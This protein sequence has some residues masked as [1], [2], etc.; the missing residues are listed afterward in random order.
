MRK[1][2]RKKEKRE[3]LLIEKEIQ[4][5][6]LDAVEKQRLKEITMKGKRPPS[7]R[8]AVNQNSV[9]KRDAE[10]IAQEIIDNEKKEQVAGGLDSDIDSDE[11]DEEM[12]DRIKGQPGVVGEDSLSSGQ[13][14]FEEFAKNT[15]LTYYK[16]MNADEKL[17]T[18]KNRTEQ[19][20]VKQLQIMEECKQ[21]ERL[22]PKDGGWQNKV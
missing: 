4:K 21:T 9:S 7:G 8:M 17:M 18:L 12:R 22:Y 15:D 19:L 20:I 5:D 2:D 13:E 6:Q 11:L 14:E 16:M 10:K 1:K 3:K